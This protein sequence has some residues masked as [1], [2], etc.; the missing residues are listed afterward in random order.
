VLPLPPTVSRF[1]GAFVVVIAMLSVSFCDGN[2]DAQP[3]PS[4]TASPSITPVTSCP[5]P[6]G[7]TAPEPQSGLPSVQVTVTGN[8]KTETLAVDV[9]STAAQ[10]TI[11]L[12]SRPRMPEGGGMLFLF[13]NPSSSGFWMRNTLIPL[14]IA[15]LGADGTVLAIRDGLPC[16]LTNLS[17]GLAYQSVLE[18]NIGW[19]ARHGMGVGSIVGLPAGLPSPQ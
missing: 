10:R 1:L 5:Q 4:P 6:P 13:K 11:G 14:S 2:P 17:P 18:V 7:Q 19:F 3:P 8:G 9:A 15:Y 16:D 12:M